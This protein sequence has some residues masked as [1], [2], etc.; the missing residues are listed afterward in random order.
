M[1]S[2]R[3]APRED[4]RRGY[5]WKRS[6]IWVPTLAGW[7]VICA[8]LLGPVVLWAFFG[9]R[10]LCVTERKSRTVLVVEG[11]IGVEGVREAKVQFNERGYEYIIAT[12]H[13]SGEPWHQ[14]R[15]SYAEEAEEQ[16]LRMG[17]PREKL[18]IAVP[19]EL[20][21]HRTFETA[22]AVRRTLESRNIHPDA[23][24]VFTRA[25]HGRRSR[26]IY[27]K[28][29]SGYCDVGVISWLP[30]TYAELPW[31]T[32]SVRTLELIKETGAYFF[33]LLLNGGRT[34]NSTET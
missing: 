13:L 16:L 34:S 27:A 15:W 31:W 11:W 6:T 18:I 33:E 3:T 32:S 9:E 25:S 1:T 4:A 24:D 7:I 22:A 30:P 8:L 20:E 19:R 17:I 21:V 23:I 14:K 29:F 26:L 28:A 10:F 5:L 12:G 2:A